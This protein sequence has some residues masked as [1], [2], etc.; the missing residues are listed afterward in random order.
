MLYTMLG[1]MFGGRYYIS[2]PSGVLTL[3]AVS[4]VVAIEYQMHS[5]AEGTSIVFWKLLVACFMT[6]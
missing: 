1:S 2:T 6:C 4:P 5:C 3:S